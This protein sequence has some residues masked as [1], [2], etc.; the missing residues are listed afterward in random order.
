MEWMGKAL[1][2]SGGRRFFLALGAGV[3]A[4]FLLWHGKLDSQNYALIVISTV[5]AFIAG[6]S[7][8]KVKT[9]NGTSTLS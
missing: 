3:T 1:E 5:G 7:W 6:N 4:S 8:E 9:K 2:T